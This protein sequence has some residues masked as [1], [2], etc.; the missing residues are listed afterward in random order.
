MHFTHW[1]FCLSS[2]ANYT[3]PSISVK[4][5]KSMHLFQ[6]KVLS[7]VHLQ[8]KIR[9]RKHPM[10]Q[11]YLSPLK[12]AVAETSKPTGGY[13]CNSRHNISVKVK[14]SDKTSTP[15]TDC[16]CATDRLRVHTG[17]VLINT[18]SLHSTPSL[19]VMSCSR[20]NSSYEPV[21]F[22]DSI[23]PILKWSL[24]YKVPDFS[25]EYLGSLHWLWVT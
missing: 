25:P 23:E 17:D 6:L 14:H 5:Y 9:R 20:T 18:C 7:H 11:T 4:W 21:L 16:V 1:R 12:A 22:N 10:N 15:H 24:S 3:R 13:F 2:C 19:G 8:Q